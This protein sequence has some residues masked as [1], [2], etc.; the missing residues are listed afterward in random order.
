[1][2]KFLNFWRT[3]HLTLYGRITILKSPALS[4]LGYNTFLLTFPFQFA[5]SVKTAFFKFMW[6]TKPKI[7]HTTAIGPK[8]NGGLDLP[9]FEIMNNALKVS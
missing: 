3:R 2:K 5:A 7:E 8:I 4:K 6:N 1:M 9:D